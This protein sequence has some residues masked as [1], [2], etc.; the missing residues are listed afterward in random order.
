[1]KPRTASRLAWSLWLIA[2]ILSALASVFLVLGR[3]T[4]PP[5]GTFGFRGFSAIFALGFATVGALIASKRSQ[6]PIGWIFLAVGIGSGWQEFSQQYAVYT[7]VDSPGVL[8]GGR[9]L[10]W[11]PTWIWVPI[12]GSVSTFLFLLFP[13]GH[14]ISRRWRLA[15][16]LSI[17]GM[18]VGAFGAA[19]ADG[20]LENFATINNPF[21]IPGSRALLL[22]T[23]SN[24][25]LMIYSLAILVAT[26]SLAIRF[27]RSRGDERQQLKWLLTSAILVFLGLT[28]SFV[29]QT[30]Y[31]TAE[32]T[33]I[34]WRG[35]DVIVILSFLTIPAAT[36]IAILKYRLYDLG[37]VINRAAIY[38][39]LAGL[40]TTFYFG[41]VYGI[42]RLV[43]Q[44]GNLA[45]SVAATAVI[46]VA[47]QPVRRQAQRLANRLIFGRRATPY[48]A[49]AQFSHRIAGSLSLEE[50]LPRMAETAA[51]GIGAARA[52]V[53]VFLPAGGERS[54]SWPQGGED[55]SYERTVEVVHQGNPVGEISIA[56]SPGDP[57]RAAEVKLLDDLASQAG[58]ALRNVGLIEELRASRQ[59][60]VAAQDTERRRIERNIHDGA[61]QQLVALKVKLGLIRRLDDQRKADEL[62]AQVEKETDEAIEN[63]RELARGIF[64]QLLVERGLEAALRAHSIKSPV[65][66]EVTSDGVGRYSQEVEAAVYFCCLEA[67]Q[68]VAKYAGADLATVNLSSGDSFLRFE[69][70]DDGGGFDSQAVRLGS[71]LQNMAD[72]VQ[73]L[74]GSLEVVSNLGTGTKVVGTLPAEGRPDNPD[75]PQG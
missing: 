73:A 71:G 55:G 8:P 37:L 35:V 38:T 30:A 5:A 58:L 25:G 63:L 57:L 59:R 62:L 46:A 66:V 11:F 68:N 9:I 42:G 2:T 14:L 1:M 43:G 53:K 54:A 74:G 6:N 17:L 41:V 33:S 51:A 65:R 52:R 70:A 32:R 34:P 49:M 3:H 7:V 44:G 4:T 64:P 28:F 50:V 40:I 31:Q 16:Y 48:E 18:T 29:F 61:Q 67:L 69:V 72:R 56:K 10:A 15:A 26:T 12:T 21:G 47:F 19:L 39:V 36:G 13:T 22:E 45:L 27:R 60:I 24:I 20:P 75:T 23:L